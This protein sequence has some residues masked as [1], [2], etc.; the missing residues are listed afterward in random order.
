MIKI[1]KKIKLNLDAGKAT[2]NPPIGSIL[3]QYGIN[4]ISFCNEYNKK[5]QPFLGL[6]IPVSII[7]NQ[8]KSINILLHIPTLSFLIIYFSL[9]NIITIEKI[10]KI[11][12]IKIKEFYPISKKKC[13]SMIKGTLKSMNIK[14]ILL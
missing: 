5:T 7:L 8:N 6:K 2:P 1:I 11:L 14:L 13:L 12:E 9:N 4:I 3:G 10:K